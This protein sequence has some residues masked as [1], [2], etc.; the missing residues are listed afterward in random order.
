MHAVAASE[1]DEIMHPD[2]NKGFVPPFTCMAFAG[3]K[4][5][6]VIQ[7]EGASRPVMN[8][9]DKSNINILHR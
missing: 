3:M 1:P 2:M 9:R 7:R 6:V 5:S 8:H 4:I